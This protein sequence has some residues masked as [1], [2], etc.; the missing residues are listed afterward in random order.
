MRI[1]LIFGALALGLYLLAPPAQA[2]DK[3]L[4]ER[5]K[6][7]EQE[8]QEFREYEKK[9]R[10]R[11]KMKEPALPV[12]PGQA[13]T[14]VG[15]IQEIARERQGEEKVPLSFGSTGSGRLLYAKP[16]LSA[17]KATVGGYGDIQFNA[18]N[19]SNLDNR[20]RNTFN[21]VR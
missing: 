18:L 5:L 14:G 19:R 9:E 10:E 15:S 3:N 13:P 1:W 4:E 16:F 21:Q 11:E 17:P 2:E 12:A 8:L 7:L 6:K 20:S